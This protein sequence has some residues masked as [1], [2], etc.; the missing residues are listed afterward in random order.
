MYFTILASVFALGIFT[1]AF[2]GIRANT[3]RNWRSL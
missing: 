3:N 2:I 1:P